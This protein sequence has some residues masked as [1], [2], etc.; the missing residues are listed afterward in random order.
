LHQQIDRPNAT[1][2]SGPLRSNQAAQIF[3]PYA[4]AMSLDFWNGLIFDDNVSLGSA[5]NP[6]ANTLASARASLRIF[7]T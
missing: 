7:L 3:S 4:V 6:V 5:L 1:D 2:A